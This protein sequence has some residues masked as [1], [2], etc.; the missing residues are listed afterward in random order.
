MWCWVLVVS[1]AVSCFC[2]HVPLSYTVGDVNITLH[3]TATSAKFVKGPVVDSKGDI[4]LLL[5]VG[6][7]ESGYGQMMKVNIK[8]N[9]V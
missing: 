5:S 1:L 8:K 3:E 2:D 7:D 4:Y 6:R 9:I